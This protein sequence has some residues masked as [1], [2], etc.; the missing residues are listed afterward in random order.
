MGLLFSKDKYFAEYKIHDDD[1]DVRY[2]FHGH[3]PQ[4]EI[5]DGYVQERRIEQSRHEPGADKGYK[6]SQK[7]LGLPGFALKDEYLIGHIGKQ[8]R[9]KPRQSIG[10]D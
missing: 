8:D 1:G 2:N 5:F 3:I 9:E 6:L 4:M 7:K 10:Q